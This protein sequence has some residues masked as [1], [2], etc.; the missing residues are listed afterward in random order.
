MKLSEGQRLAYATHGAGPAL[1]C[2]AW[3]VSHLEEDWQAPSFQALFGR[4]AERFTVVRYDRPGAG[5]SDRTRDAVDLDSEVHT[6]SQLVDHLKLPTFSM[7]AVSC[8]GPSALAYAAKNPQRVTKMVF[9]GSFVRGEDVGP[10]AL[11]RAMQGLV[12]AHWG[13]GSQTITNLFAPDLPRQETK[14]ISRQHKLSASPQMAAKLLSLT[15]DVDVADRANQVR[16]PSLVLHRKKDRTIRHEAGMELAA[17]LPEAEFKTLEGNAHVPWLGEV[18][19]V[20]DAILGFLDSEQLSEAPLPSP[21]AFEKQGDVWTLTFAGQSVVLKDARG[22]SDLAILIQNANQE[23]HV[24]TLWSGEKTAAALPGADP[25]LDEEALR[26]YKTRL[27]ELGSSI[28]RA[29][30]RGNVAAAERY[31]EEREALAKEL[32]GAVGLHGRQRSLNAPS[33]RARKAV[34][35]RIRASIKKIAKVHAALGAHLEA[36]VTTGTFCEYAQPEQTEWKISVR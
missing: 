35:A 7:F 8:A 5:L 18:D 25:I 30:A 16:T 33:E 24:A 11:K 3:W 28:S 10:Q 34:T 20:R 22:L 19:A 15:F 21:N 31:Q 2:P 9:F 12:E 6:L 4:L 26:S 1:V 14:Q 23:L 17:A 36:Q 27:Q 29:E 13:M 32:R